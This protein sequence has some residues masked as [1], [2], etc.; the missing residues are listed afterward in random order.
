MTQP[1]CSWALGLRTMTKADRDSGVLT[2]TG[3]PGVLAGYLL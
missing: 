2:A 3:S 1:A